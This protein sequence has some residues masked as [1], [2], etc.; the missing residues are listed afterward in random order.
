MTFHCSKRG[1][2]DTY[3]MKIFSLAEIVSP[4]TSPWS[5]PDA[6]N[7]SLQPSFYASFDS[8][9]GF[10]FADVRISTANGKVYQLIYCY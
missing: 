4:L 3:M 9:T 7:T 8:T 2:N 5:Q 1:G 6:V 10:P